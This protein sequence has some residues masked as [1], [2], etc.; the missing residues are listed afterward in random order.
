VRLPAECQCGAAVRVEVD[1][2]R[3]DP[4][5]L[6]AIAAALATAGRGRRAAAEAVAAA[7]VGKHYPGHIHVAIP[8][9]KRGTLP[10]GRHVGSPTQ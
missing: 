3:Y 2:G 9:A 6:H 5:E 10:P 1:A 7:E 8:S 4:A